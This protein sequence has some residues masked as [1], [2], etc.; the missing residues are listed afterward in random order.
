M[1]DDRTHAD[2]P[3]PVDEAW[4]ADWTQRSRTVPVPDDDTADTTC[5]SPHTPAPQPPHQVLIGGEYVAPLR[6]GQVDRLLATLGQECYREQLR[7]AL[8]DLL[9]RPI[10]QAI[11]D[12]IR[13][14]R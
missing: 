2:Q 5:P 8:I 1:I 9:A 10:G 11:A 13:A 3:I 12:A 4:W 14:G 6:R 7:E